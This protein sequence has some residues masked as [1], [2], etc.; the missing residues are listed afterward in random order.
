ML[1]IWYMTKRKVGYTLNGVD[2]MV[3]TVVF[4]INK[5]GNQYRSYN[6]KYFNNLDVIGDDIELVKTGIELMIPELLKPKYCY[7][8]VGICPDAPYDDAWLV[9]LFGDEP[10][11]DK[12]KVC[13][14]DF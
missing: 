11:T 4:R 6:N 1:V 3:W 14:P 9:V 10:I 7:K 8:V 13:I 2:D 12:S 5:E